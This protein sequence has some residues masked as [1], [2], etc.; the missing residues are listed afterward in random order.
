MESVTFLG[1]DDFSLR[2][3]Q[4]GWILDRIFDEGHSPFLIGVHCKLL[5]HRQCADKPRLYSKVEDIWKF[6]TR[7]TG[8]CPFSNR[9][10]MSFSSAHTLYTGVRRARFHCV[11]KYAYTSLLSL[12]FTVHIVNYE[13]TNQ[14]HYRKSRE[15][16]TRLRVIWYLNGVI[17]KVN[18][19]K[20]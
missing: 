8:K 20:Q 12:A 7:D 16:N 11:F 15:E 3:S 14:P 6:V 17:F 4:V 5:T 19:L 9:F 2:L 18:T 13:P 10:P 1:T